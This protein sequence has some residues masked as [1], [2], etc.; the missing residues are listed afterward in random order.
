MIGNRRESKVYIIVALFLV[1]FCAIFFVSCSGKC[2]YT[3][4]Y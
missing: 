1:L 2:S 4:I 3:Y